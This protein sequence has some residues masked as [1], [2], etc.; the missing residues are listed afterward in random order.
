MLAVMGLATG[1]A[2]ALAVA[3]RVFDAFANGGAP[4]IADMLH[5]DVRARPAIYGAPELNGR[6]AVC[7]WI[8]DVARRGAEFEARPLDYEVRGGFVIVRG[9]LRHHDGRTLSENQVFWL[10]EIH[11]GLITRMESYPSRRSA[12]AAAV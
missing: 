7:E 8:A 6:E 1:P 10:Y 3:R 4:A 2:G 9:Y 11:D 5:P 12:V